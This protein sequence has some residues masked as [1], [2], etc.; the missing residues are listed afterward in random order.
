MSVILMGATIACV[1]LAYWS[2]WRINL[3]E[4]EPLGIYPLTPVYAST[5]I[6]SWVQMNTGFTR[7]STVGTGGDYRVDDSLCAALRVGLSR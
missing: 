4:S 5:A 1:Q 3:T 7:V 2:G 6:L